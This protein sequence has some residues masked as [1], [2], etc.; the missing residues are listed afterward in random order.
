MNKYGE[1]QT[2]NVIHF[3][4]KLPAVQSHYCRNKSNKLYLL[5]DYRDM[6]HL[7]RNVYLKDNDTKALGAVT[8]QKFKIF[9]T[10]FNIGFHLSKKDKCLQCDRVKYMNE[11]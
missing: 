4:K 9:K 1:N 11:E 3:I 7:Y 2:Q 8:D 6:S 5:T 10:K